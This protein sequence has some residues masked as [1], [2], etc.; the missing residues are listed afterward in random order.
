[1]SFTELVKTRKPDKVEPLQVGRTG[2]LKATYS[3]GV[4]AV[5]KF[6]KGEL[7]DGRRKQRGLPI[8]TQPRHEVAYYQLAKMFGL[9]LVP[10]TTLITYKN[11]LASAQ[12]FMPAVRPVDLQPKL[13]DSDRPDWPELLV[14]VCRQVPRK[15][16]RQLLML[17]IIA[18]A[19]DR[20]SNNIGLKLHVIDNKPAYRLVAWDNATTF[21]KTFV[22]YHNVFHKFLFRDA[23]KFDDQWPVMR[24]V[25]K[26]TFE[27]TLAPF[28]T[29]IE[30][31]HAWK[32]LRFFLVYPY[33]LPWV[34]CSKGN[35]DP[36][37]FPAYASYFEAIDEES[38]Q[39]L[40]A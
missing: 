11:Q 15:Y 21:G 31:E 24:S 17:D 29:D 37:G 6:A 25:T 35:D 28:L 19:R 32:R 10:E 18:G 22:K 20:H 16:W 13:K 34:I 9:D 1:M 14:E 33:R 40:G 38:P 8:R 2:A 36:N 12:Q 5:I 27:K 4:Q 3:N 7:P 23:V 39:S 26:A 30:V